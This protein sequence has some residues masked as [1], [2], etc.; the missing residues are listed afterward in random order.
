MILHIGNGKSPDDNVAFEKTTYQVTLDDDTPPGTPLVVPTVLTHSHVTYAFQDNC[1]HFG[2]HT[3]SGAI[4]LKTWLTEQKAK[5]VECL[6]TVQNSEG[7]SDE[8]KISVK[9]QKTNQK[10]PVFRSQVYRGSIRENSPAGSVVLD[11][12]FLPLVVTADDEDSGASGLVEYRILGDNEKFSIDKYSGLITTLS[13]LDFEQSQEHQFHVQAFDL[14]VPRRRSL[15]PTLIIISV[16]DDNDMAPE[17]PK[18]SIDVQLLLPTASGVLIG[19]Q[20]ATDKDTVGVIR[21]FVKDPNFHV[22]ASGDV[23]VR[24]SEILN[25]GPLSLEIFASDSVRSTS[26]TMNIFISDPKDS[27]NGFRFTQDHYQAVITENTTYQ[28]GTIISS[29][30]TINDKGHVEF[31]IL[32]PH[33]A[34]F[35]HPATGVLSATGEVVDR[36]IS[37]LIRLIIQAKTIEK[38]VK[39]AQSVITIQ[40]EDIN[41]NAPV[42]METP[43][44]TAISL[45]SEVGSLVIRTMATDKDSGDHGRIQYSSEDIPEVF[46]LQNGS[47]YLKKKLLEIQEFRFHVTAQDSSLKT[48]EAVRIRVVDGARPIF[49]QNVYTARISRGTLKNAILARVTAKSN[50]QRAENGGFIGYRLIRDD[51]EPLISVDFESGEVRLLAD[52]KFMETDSEVEIEAVEVTRPKLTSTA[53]LRILMTSSEDSEGPKFPEKSYEARI[54]ESAAPGQKI[55]RVTAS[56]EDVEYS[57]DGDSEFRIDAASGDVFVV[58]PL[59]YESRQDYKLKVIATKGS[60]AQ[61]STELHVYLDDVNDEKPVFLSDDVKAHV[62]DSAA[63]GQFITIMSATDLDTVS[64]LPG[65]QKLL[66]RIV[67]GDETLFNISP[68][69]GEVQLARAIEPEDLNGAKTVKTLNISVTDGMFTAFAKLSVDILRNGAMQL[70]LKFEQSQYVASALENT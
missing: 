18:K 66:F 11:D 21:Y 49:E 53:K 54:P 32:N 60:L 64:S 40:V 31:R 41:D 51:K 30:A 63:P 6:L 43:Y 28:P 34:F 44:D 58:K 56:E 61:G 14:G 57:L 70:P 9:I 3:L 24:N 10:A 62:Y 26:Y 13:P 2:V 22:D 16:L 48:S 17:F 33:N 4:H 19:G 7:R 59:N 55:V 65:L 37:P 23:R 20:R 36:E 8:A 69:T 12:T 45:N 38:E 25:P 42:F 39:T 15:M 1:T 5:T 27:G 47:I 35:I 68:T 50:I 29:V 52:P 67:D 46:E